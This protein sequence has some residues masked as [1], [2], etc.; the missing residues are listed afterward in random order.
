[1]Q[2]KEQNKK[3][4]RRPAFLRKKVMIPVL[5]GII[6]A[7]GVAGAA[8]LLGDKEPDSVLVSAGIQQ[9]ADS[10]YLAASA[11][12][13]QVI[14]F[15]P[16]WFDNTLG[17]GQVRSVT[18]TALPPVTEGMLKLGYGEV[19]LGQTIPRETLSYLTFTP[20]DG[21][22]KSSFSFTPTTEDGNCGYEFCCHLNV[23][24]GTNCCPVEKG[25]VMAVS[26]HETL[27][28]NGML[29]AE[30][31]DGDSLHFEICAYPAN[32]VLSLDAAT[33]NFTYTPAIGFCGEDTF[34][35]RAQDDNGAFSGISTVRITVRD[36]T[37][38]YI[39]SDIADSNIQTAALRVTEAGLLGGEE[40]SG[41]HYFHPKR[42][43]TRAAFVAILL[44]AA[45]IKAPDADQTG[46]AD[47][48]DIPAGM[49]GAIRY[50]KEQGWLGE[51]DTFR[52]NDA[53]TRAEAAAI[54]AKVLGLTAPGYA[55]TVRD[56]AAI[57]V[58]V[59]DAIYALFEG[60]YITTFA[61]GN[62]APA[63]AMTRED[64]ARFF[65]RILDGKDTE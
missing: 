46:F 65:A 26:T 41:K 55:E 58:D 42:E 20:N 10:A 35:W 38:G 40:V 31:P 5:C 30:D 14:S 49:K 24:A 47:D 16:E 3:S 17:G 2:N 57:P 19:S 9:L 13:G 37:T 64:A 29:S 27:T 53:I 15:T 22:E 61:D 43:L 50:A 7:G 18:L 36:L 51:E 45:E 34:T 12:A 32:G 52:P 23:T 21:V 11:P 48:A 56:F 8:L 1:M 25:S 44:D 28:L 33:G 6:V 60:G 59:A 63:A 39:F 62:L 54:A 4:N